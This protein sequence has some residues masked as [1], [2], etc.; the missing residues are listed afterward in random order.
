MSFLENY[1]L[2]SENLGSNQKKKLC[3]AKCLCKCDYAIF[4]IQKTYGLRKNESFGFLTIYF[5][6]F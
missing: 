5:E 3:E 2:I 6:F 4:Y 1:P